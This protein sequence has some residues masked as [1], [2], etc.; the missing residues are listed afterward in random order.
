[1]NIQYFSESSTGIFKTNISDFIPTYN[2]TEPL[3]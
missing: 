3:C 1:M 2:I